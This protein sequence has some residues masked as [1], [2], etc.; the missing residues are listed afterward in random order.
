MNW[1][2]YGGWA[3]A[4]IWGWH[5]LQAALG[6]P[7]LAEL[8][9]E[10]WD[11]PSEEIVSKTTGT[12]APKVSIIV[13]AR[14]EES[15]I[16]PAMQSLMCVDYSA[17]EVLAVNDRS[18]DGT[19]RILTA[20][21]EQ[22]PGKLKV[23]HVEELPE[24]WLGKT[25][26]MGLAA[27]NAEGEWLLF[28]DADVAQS[29]DVL[30]RAIGY[31]EKVSVDHLV[32]MPTMLTLDWGERMMIALFQSLFIFAQRPWKV[33]DPNARD[34]IGVGA[35]N[36][37]RRNVYDAVGGYD[38]LRLAIVDDMKLGEMVK[39]HRYAST[40]A[41][42][43]GMVRIH[44]AKGA[45]GMV[46]NLVKNFF[47]AM[48]YNVAI[49]LCA[50]FMLV[51]VFLGPWAGTVFAQGWARVGYLSSIAF[52]FLIYHGMSKRTDISPIYSLLHPVATILI[53]YTILLSMVTTIWQGGVVWRGTKYS[54]DE[55]RRS[56]L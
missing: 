17:V 27:R 35:F 18:S 46:H 48:R 1:P 41:F 36:L 9:D 4:A 5:G 6:M 8:T 23:L 42:A 19:G 14:N 3:L 53:C 56:G 39:K 54:L 31:A 50:V 7:R 40:C 21:A 16:A 2:L 24:G 15:T 22:H 34:F 45:L 29:P 28:T 37:I 51:L 20:I 12:R 49:V 11:I 25:H 55:L 32:V 43:K 10:N 38:R 52:L 44:W 47:A 26:A 30:R 13:P 33:S